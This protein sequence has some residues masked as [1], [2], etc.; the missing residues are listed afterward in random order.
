MKSNRWIRQTRRTPFGLSALACLVALLVFGVAC[1]PEPPSPPELEGEGEGGSAWLSGTVDERFQAVGSQMGG[2][3]QAML[4]VGHRYE[5]LY[6]AI[7]DGNWAYA[8]YQLEKIGDAVERGIIRRPGRAESA[9]SLFLDAPLPEMMEAVHSGDEDRIRAQFEA[10]TRS[11]NQCH[12]VEEME[13]VVIG[14][15]EARR[16]SVQPEGAQR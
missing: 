10:F 7:Q 14:P 8:E 6:W 5:D 11:C 15:P 9:E 3:S 16:T 2:F 1:Q 4:E 12:V 13:F